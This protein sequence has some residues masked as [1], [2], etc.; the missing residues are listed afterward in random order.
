MPNS[1]H[2][3]IMT[4]TVENNSDEKKS[5]NFVEQLVEEDISEGKKGCVTYGSTTLTP[6]KRTTNM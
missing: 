2:Q 4:V 6:P 5:L 1:Y 3:N